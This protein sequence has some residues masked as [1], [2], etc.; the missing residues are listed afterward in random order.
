MANECH[1]TL[2]V[3]GSEK[4]IAAFKRK[5][6]GIDFDGIKSP[7]WFD[8]LLPAPAELPQEPNAIDH[9]R[10]ANWGTT[11]GPWGVRID[12]NRKDEVRYH[13]DTPWTPCVSLLGNISPDFPGL[14]FKLTYL[15][16]LSDYEGWVIIKNGRIRKSRHGEIK[17][18]Y[19]ETVK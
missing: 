3:K 6:K 4:E 9:W 7:L 12:L 2:I 18:K 11:G 14:T 19:G 1:N 15:C 5:A 13:F 16:A 10:G 8:G 17:W